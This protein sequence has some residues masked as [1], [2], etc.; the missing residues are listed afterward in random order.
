MLEGIITVAAMSDSFPMIQE[1]GV[2]NYVA[3]V[4]SGNKLLQFMC[5]HIFPNVKNRWRMTHMFSLSFVRFLPLIMQQHCKSKVDV[6][7]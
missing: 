2:Q 5:I 1:L 4:Y 6:T 3:Q 7:N